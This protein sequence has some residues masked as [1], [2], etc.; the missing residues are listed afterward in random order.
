MFTV[1]MRVDEAPYPGMFEGGVA[2]END[3]RPS[4]NDA[5]TA[6]RHAEP[7]GFSEEAV[8][9]LTHSSATLLGA[10][11]HPRLRPRLLA[12]SRSRG[13]DQLRTVTS[14]GRAYSP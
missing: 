8:K 3:N 11:R 5:E 2:V 7:L 14:V 1:K 6:R 10:D 4:S 12:S 9:A 13:G